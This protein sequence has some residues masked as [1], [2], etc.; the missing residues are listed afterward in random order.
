MT[1]P[2]FR[3]VIHLSFEIDDALNGKHHLTTTQIHRKVMC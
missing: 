1:L 3:Y 2:V